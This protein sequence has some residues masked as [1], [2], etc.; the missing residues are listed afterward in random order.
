MRSFTSALQD[1]CARGLDW[2]DARANRLFTSRGNPL[3]HSGAIV[4]VLLVVLLVTGLYLLLFYRLGDPWGSVARVTEQRWLGNWMRGLHRFASDAA[5]VAAGVHAFRIFAQRRTWGPRALAWLTGVGLV[6]LLLACGWT[7][8][9][10]VWDVQAQ[11]LAVEG[12]RLLD[13]LPIFSEPISRAFV[14]ERALP[15]AFFFLNL[16]AHIAIPVGML[17]AL[18]LH[19]SRVARAGVLPPRSVT[20]WL[21]AGLLALS[22]FW[23]VGMSPEA[24]L[25][26]VPA[27][28]ALDLFY[29][30]WLPLS[31]GVPELVVWLTG[32]GLVLLVVLVPVWSRP[33]AEDAPAKSKV[34]ER[35][36]TGCE[37]CM[38]D[39]PYE[40]IA[41]VERTDGRAGVV[42]R[43]DPALCVGCGICI[44]SCAPMG[45]GPEGRTG[46]DQLAAARGF[47]EAERPGARD[48]VVVGCE[49]SAARGARAAGASLF[50]LP[51]AGNVHT[52]TI[53]LL[54]REGA[55]GVLVVSCPPR[56]CR[57]REGVRWLEQRVHHG[58]EAE[59]KERVD[60]RRVRILHAAAGE[61]ELLARAIGSFRAEV[62]ALARPTVEEVDLIELCRAVSAP[63]EESNGLAAGGAFAPRPGA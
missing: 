58:R 27:G 32:L 59:L 29:V 39:C 54:L 13:V 10:M 24:D 37:Q 60:R 3:Y 22:L 50:S 19:V 41:M 31:R 34:N 4:V 52:S 36:C 23:P 38:L 12:A 16:F 53:E 18:W 28:A 61:R 17:F 51:C 44:G 7:G 6:A 14:G 62:A 5:V 49:W 30:F 11:L 40:A 43:V 48:V 56:D 55:G 46:R 47:L 8:Y 42:A 35:L 57:N 9:V 25:Y 26:R 2:L 33:R 20:R 1:R 45:V 21:V 63:P 15:G